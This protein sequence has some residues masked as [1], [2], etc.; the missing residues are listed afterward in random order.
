[1]VDL[2][3]S[4][5]NAGSS[6]QSAGFQRFEDFSGVAGPIE[7]VTWWGVDLD[8]IEG[9]NDFGMEALDTK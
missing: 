2:E 9:T 4:D 7:R 6:D 8:N 5:F 1:M 3:P